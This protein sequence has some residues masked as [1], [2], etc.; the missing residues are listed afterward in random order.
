MLRGAAGQS[1]SKPSARTATTIEIEAHSMHFTLA[2]TTTRLSGVELR[3]SGTVGQTLSTGV[4]SL[5]TELF[6]RFVSFL[7]VSEQ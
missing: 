4:D 1:C 2:G 3:S 5:V 6:P 7:H